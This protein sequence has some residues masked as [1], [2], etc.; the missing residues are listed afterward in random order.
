MKLRALF[1]AV[2]FLSLLMLFGLAAVPFL[3]LSPVSPVFAQGA[4]PAF[5]PD[6]EYTRTV[7]ENTDPYHPIGDPV[8]ATGD[9]VTYSLQNAGTSNFGIDYFTGQLLVG[10]RLDHEEE[11]EYTVTVKATD[12][13][14]RTTTQKVTINVNNVDE[15]GQITLAW[16]LDGSNVQFTATLLDPDGDPSDTT[17]KWERL[18]SQNGQASVIPNAQTDTFTKTTDCTDCKYLRA[19][20]TYTD[21]YDD[22]TNRSP[23][24]TLLVERRDYFA[25]YNLNF[26]AQTS[27]GYGCSDNEADLCINLPRNA[28]PGDDIY[29]PAS[30]YYTKTGE[31]ERYPQRGEISYSLGGTESSY[32]D[33]DPVTGDLLPKGGHIYEDRSTFDVTI[34]ATD[35]SGDDASVTIRLIPSGSQNNISVSGPQRLEYPENGTWRVAAYSA[36]KPDTGE[37]DDD[38]PDQIRGWIIAVQPGGGD[39]DFFDID[40][41]GVL[42]FTQPPDYEDPADE[43]EDRTYSFSLMVYDTN[44]PNRERPAQTFYSVTVIVY[45]VDEDLEIRGPTNVKHPENDAS[46]VATYTAER[47][48]GTLGWMLGGKDKNLFSINSSGELTFNTTPDYENPFDSTDDPDDRND[49]ELSVIVTDGT[50]TKSKDPVRVMVTD[51]NEPPSFDEGTTA[52]RNVG[53]NAGPNEDV[54]APVEATDPEDAALNYNLTGTDDDASFEI[55]RWNGQLRTISGVDY[56]TESSYTVTVTATDQGS[57]TDTI[58]V[59]ITTNEE[60][61]APVFDDTDLDT[62]LEVS[63]NTAAATNIGA[64]I[65]ATDEDNP[66]LT[67]TLEGDDKDSFTIVSASGQIQTKSG[68]TYN[69]EDPGDADTDNEYLVTVKASDGTASDTIDVTINVNDVNETPTFPSTETGAR[70]VAENTPSSQAIGAPVAATDPDNEKPP[71]T[72]TLTYTLGGTDAASFDID[73]SSGQ[74]RTKDALDHD[75]KAI[76]TVTVS[77]RDSKDDSGNDDMADDDTIAVTITVTGENEPPEFAAE[78]DT[79]DIAENTEAGQNIGGP[80]AATDPDN[81]DTLTYT[82]DAASD[83]VF[84]II[85]D[86][87]Q[88]K[89]ETALDFE[90]KNSYAVT[91]TA[92]DGSGAS[93]SILVTIDVINVD[94]AGTV[95]FSPTPPKAGTLLT[96]TVTD[97]D[98][99]VTGVTWQW[100][101][102]D[103][104]NTGFTDISGGTSDNY[105]PIATDVGKYLKAIASYTDGEG[106]GKSAEAVSTNAV[107]SGNT[108]PTFTDGD[109]DNT[110]DP[111]TF[112]VE[113]NSPPT[114][115]VGTVSTTDSDTDT[116]TYSLVG[117]PTEITAFNAAL[118][119]DTATGEITVKAKDSLDYE[120]TDTYTFDIGVSDGKDAA[121]DTDTATIDSTVSVTI[122]VTDV[123]EPP[124]FDETGPATRTVA[125]NTGAGENI[126]SAFT[127]TDPD[128]GATLTYT[129]DQTGAAVFDIDAPGQLK[130]KARVTYDHETKDTYSF[131]VSVRDSQDEH[132]AP[133]TVTDATIG[134]TITVTNEEEDGTVTF[135][136][137][138]PQAGIELTASL[139]DPDVVAPNSTTWQ[140]AI[141]DTSGNNFGNITGATNASYTPD[142]DNVDKYL[143]ATATYTD[144]HGANKTAQGEPGNAVR[145]AHNP[146]QPPAF[147]ES[148]TTTPLS[149]DIAENTGAGIN[150]GTPVTA[151]DPDHTDT[152]AYSLDTTSSSVFHIVS[153]TGQIQTKGSLGHETK[154]TYTVTVKATDPSNESDTIA[155]T[156]NVTDVDEP[157]GKPSAPTVT[158]K[159]GTYYALTVMWTKPANTGPAI[160]SYA[161]EYRKHDVT[162]WTDAIRTITG[163]TTAIDITGLLPDTEYFARVQ[164]T[165]DEGTGEWSEEGE[166]TTAVKPATD[167]FYLT[168]DYGA[169]TY[170]VTENSSVDI[171]VRLSK[172]G[173]PRAA[174][175]KLDIPITITAGTAESGDYTVSGLTSDD[176]LAFVPGESSKTFEISASRDNDGDDETVD[177]GF[178]SPLPARVTA[179]TL[180][181]SQVTID[182]NY[183]KSGGGGGGTPPVKNPPPPANNPPVFNPGTVETISV[184]E[185]TVA[186]TDIGD[187][188]TAADGDAN[189]TL[190][191]SLDAASATVFTIVAD[192]G[193][194]QTKA[195]LNYEVRN[196]YTVTVTATDSSDATANTDV[197]INVTDVEEPPGKLDAPTVAAKTGTH[198]TLTV[199]WDAPDNTGPDITSYAVQYRKHDVM[200]WTDATGT[201]TGTTTTFDITGL[202]PD[203]EYFARVQAANDEG[204]GEWSGEGSGTTDIKPEA[205]WFELTVNYEEATYTVTEGSAV[206]ITVELSKD[207]TAE[208][209]DRKLAV[210]ITVTPGTAETG[211]YTVNDLTSD[212][213]LAFV[214]GEPSKTFTVVANQD[215]D[216]SNETLTLGFGTLPSDGKVTAGNPATALVTINDNT[217]SGGGGGGGTPPVK[218]PPPPANNPPVFNPG[219]VEAIS[220]AENTVA[221]TD[222]G[223]PVTAADS[224]AN[225]TLTYSLDAA[226]AKVFTIVDDTGQ[227]QTKAAL[228]YEVKNSYTVTVTA[229]DSS[230][231]TAN[232][233]V[234]VNVTDVEEPPGKPDAPTVEPASTNGHN[235]LSVSWN[236]PY[237]TG[238]AITSYTV[239]YRKH[240]STQWTADNLTISGATA[241]ITGLLPDT[242]Y[243]A[244]VRATNDEGAG[245]WSN[246]GY[247]NTEAIPVS[248]HLDLT[249]NYQA[250]AYTVTEGSSVTVTVTLSAT[251]DRALAIPITITADSAESGDYT[252]GGLDGS[253]ALAFAS[254]ENSKAFTITANSDAD[255][256]DETLDLG[257]GTLPDK[258]TAGATSAATVTINDQIVTLPQRTVSYGAASYT[259]NEGSSATI[260]VTLSQPADRALSV[261]ITVTRGTAEV[262]DYEVSGLTGGGVAF[263]QGA[264]SGSFTITAV[265]DED[266]SNETLSLGLGTLPSGISA[267]SPATASVTIDDD[268]P[269]VVYNPPPRRRG[270]GSSRRRGSGGWV[271]GSENHP[272]VFMEGPTASREVPEIARK[273]ANIGYPV[274]A[275]DPNLD[276]LTYALTGDDR[277]SFDIGPDTGQLLTKAP[278]DFET[279]PGY[280]VGVTVSDGR[281]GSDSI[282]VSIGV[283]DV[284]EIIFDRD[285]Q[286]VARVT[287]GV[288]A[289]IVTPDGSGTVALP[290]GSRDSDYYVRIGS[291]ANACARDAPPGD[292]YVYTTVEIFDLQ[293]NLEEDVT[294]DQPAVILLKLDAGKLGGVA[295]ALA[296]PEAGGIRVYRRAGPQEEWTEVDFTL[297]SDD[298]GGI[299]VFVTGVLQFGCFVAVADTSVLPPAAPAADPAPEPTSTPTPMIIP[300]APA[301]VS[302]LTGPSSTASEPGEGPVIPPVVSAGPV[303]PV[304][305]TGGF[306]W[307]LLLLI[308]VAVT[309]TAAGIYA[310]RRRRKAAAV[311]VIDPAEEDASEV[312]PFQVTPPVA[313]PVAVTTPV[314]TAPALAPSPEATPALE[315]PPRDAYGVALGRDLMIPTRGLKAWIFRRRKAASPPEVDPAEADP[316]EALP[317][318]AAPAVAGPARAVPEL[319]APPRAALGDAIPESTVPPVWGPAKDV[320]KVE[321][322]KDIMVPTRGIYTA[323]LH[324]QDGEDF[325]EEAPPEIEPPAAAP[326][327]EFPPQAGPASP[328]VDPD[329]LDPAEVLPAKFYGVEIGRDVMIPTRRRRR[330]FR[331]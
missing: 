320:H 120:T 275:T 34:T 114:T 221:G 311:P 26:E 56:G 237:N 274:T 233:D 301:A 294:L 205:D 25:N 29:Y 236:A 315:A 326:L 250:A 314:R 122:N 137:P 128:F 300:A 11:D 269:P 86:S 75:A 153:D 305:E 3:S 298:E 204:T 290:A 245:G 243:A 111:L 38:N 44:P 5:D 319:P 131:T 175:R 323:R 184:A 283:T 278:L 310:M 91:V 235:T 62:T 244:T 100:L 9:E 10:T 193:Q 17:W 240:D 64:P 4:G 136:N 253:N 65:T 57:L 102:S 142:D 54:G 70:S 325:F 61:D 257:F 254:G 258:V 150:I 42:R 249:V 273:A 218:N 271:M 263:S 133:D 256:D 226:S 84:D 187:P 262:R 287:P 331:R 43:N 292:L 156:I 20:A 317:R 259:V 46:T 161:V 90:V 206:T 241:T 185:N 225:D 228:N 303:A 297:V 170:D 77:V 41:D 194:L 110:P 121:G 129:L 180:V 79:H 96:A 281:G 157:P 172:D 318:R 21:R 97:P 119:L 134:V 276:K 68:V 279:R 213:T 163:A 24:K 49:Y 59:T 190:T 115:P 299:T 30:V 1:P 39:G 291:G 272:P 149:F 277:D 232:T 16:Q 328:E 198:D 22:Q 231:A 14:D 73:T 2:A 182:D 118:L 51:V 40:D 113:E 158:A 201:I 33:V 252:A 106:S 282:E 171:I 50:D 306:P 45:N 152:I 188:I 251:A 148:Y 139:G 309:I 219:T 67:Y 293:G 144:G 93:D 151:T 196:S 69:Y 105:T 195:A 160:N 99:N 169:A 265:Q 159:T 177:L 203:T 192:T 208:A 107:S 71:N 176:A 123:N 103:S 327:E 88:L 248:G 242:R 211:D 78:T 238:P 183:R 229:T 322:G 63:E 255:T 35:A 220:V 270:G 178:G 166:G 179:G 13:S 174:D 191:Y 28:T 124:E 104:A 304:E 224:D 280:A 138:T 141:S 267:G 288:G 189:D 94:E 329:G 58:T 109:Y 92:T 147:R 296:I 286:T 6:G 126:G 154:A 117:E 108:P 200:G 36:T 302:G 164:A 215:S 247:G 37:D 15:P 112:N 146:N 53:E 140:W 27:N 132:G 227:L 214:P 168:V 239:E 23:H 125:E 261:P 32:F 145:A 72:Q 216:R 199:T 7:D 202:L 207:G 116:L 89:T 316:T 260:D 55:G 167:W 12:S 234:T 130:T 313:V 135:T 82:L 98:G 143:R 324:P 212:G 285:T 31:G 307:W 18:D 289:A 173:S 162:V 321:L 284:R 181:A 76:Y 295:D 330:P 268:D 230:G 186:S 127:A 266:S 264:G 81:G 48:E 60:N 222:I 165:N 223:D 217:R 8:T 308:A 66:S 155:V 19:T 87:G 80:V 95:A 210:P 312:P 52:T 85:D 209:A 47:A 246:E 101:I 83:A 197:T 74:L